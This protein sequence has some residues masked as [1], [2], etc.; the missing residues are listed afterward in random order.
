MSGT[1]PERGRCASA[2][3]GSRALGTVTAYAAAIA[4]FAYALMSLYWAVG[5]RGLVSTVGGYV[6]QFDRRGGAVPVLVALAAAAAKVVGGLL[7]LAMVRPWGRVIPRRWLLAGST[8][9]SV[10]LVGYGG[11]NVL[12]GALVLSGVIHPAGGVDR[13]ALRWH[14]GVWDLWFLVWGILLA[15]A[16]VSYRRRTRP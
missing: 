11:L 1:G 12:V 4:A 15:L 8:A 7:A 14:V 13:M 2:A 3:L 16:T 9:A 5:G 6:A 10:L